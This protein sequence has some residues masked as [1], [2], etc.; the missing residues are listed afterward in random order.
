MEQPKGFRFGHRIIKATG[1]ASDNSHPNV[2]LLQL[3]RTWLDLMFL[4]ILAFLPPG[5]ASKLRNGYQEWCLPEQIVL[6][7]EKDNWAEEFE[8]EKA[9]YEHLRPLQGVNIPQFYGCAEYNGKRA[10]VLSNI[11]GFCLATPEGAVLAEKDLRE[12]LSQAL[13]ALA[14]MGVA[15]DDT[16]LDN[17]HLVTDKGKDKIMIVD[18][19]LVDSNSSEEDLGFAISCIVD[20]LID[21]YRMHLDCLQHDGHLLPRRDVR[22]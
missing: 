9:T 5:L 12:L 2:L 14:D 8:R 10:I 15:H 17:F 20:H 7:V 21:N 6:K 22:K 11:G 13:N 3:Q 1:A 4:A 19:E 16:K 18:L